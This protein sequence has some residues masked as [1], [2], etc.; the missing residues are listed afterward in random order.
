[1][2]TPCSA[3]D[4]SLRVEPNKIIR[5]MKAAFA[6]IERYLPPQSM[7][8]SLMD[9]TR[10]NSL[11]DRPCGV[12]RSYVVFDPRGRAAKCQMDF[13]NLV[14]DFSR[15]DPLNDIRA[16]PRGVQNPPATEKAGCR[17]CRWIRFCAGG[18]PLLA[19]RTSGSFSA[20]SPYCRVFK[21]L[22]PEVIRLEGL[23]L[24]KWAE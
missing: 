18:C 23:R 21:A 11:H 9:M 7:L 1:M 16:D 5:S 24:L 3:G 4:L 15:P 8:D 20:R 22:V 2:E 12:G 19:Y 14:S 13:E 17:E 6:V 10:L